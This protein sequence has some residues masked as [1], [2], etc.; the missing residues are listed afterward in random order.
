MGDD[1]LAIG[2]AGLSG[3][4]LLCRE[5]R[6][7]LLQRFPSSFL[8]EVSRREEE[9]AGYLPGPDITGTILKE[10][11]I[12]LPAGEGGILSALWKMAEASDTGLYISYS[13]IPIRQET[14][15]ICEYF[16]LNPY[17]LYSKGMY[18]CALPGAGLAE[19]ALKARGIPSCVIGA[20]APG[21][22]RILRGTDGISYL[23]RPSPDE[24]RK[25]I[26]EWQP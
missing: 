3:S 14:I 8:R 24:I 23:T 1:I 22:Q 19:M 10:A 7:A 12:I 15:E 21:K 26:S 13:L 20:A 5:K 9:M 4:A 11:H 25:V 16:D 17:R 2:Y 6:E 18:V